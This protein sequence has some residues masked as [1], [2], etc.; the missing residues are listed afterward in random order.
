MA[1][2]KEWQCPAGDLPL[3]KPQLE[4][5]PKDFSGL[6]HG[7]S[8]SGTVAFSRRSRYPWFWRPVLPRPFLNCNLQTSSSSDFK[9][10][11]TCHCTL[12]TDE[13]LTMSRLLLRMSGLT[14]LF[15]ISPGEDNVQHLE[16]HKAEAP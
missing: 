16:S 3:T 10:E 5:Q 7:H 13:Q 12:G 11:P 8:L 6:A 15:S 4:I 1:A 2:D 9:E 14:H